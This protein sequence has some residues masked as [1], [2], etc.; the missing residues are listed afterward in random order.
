MK[1]RYIDL[2]KHRG[3]GVVLDL[4]IQIIDIFKKETKAQ[5]KV[6]GLG[7]PI[8]V[9]FSDDVVIEVILI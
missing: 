1:L 4:T 5:L 7:S 2:V 8:L 9:Y 3:L 6:S